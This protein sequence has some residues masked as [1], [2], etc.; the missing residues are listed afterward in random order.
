MPIRWARRAVGRYLRRRLGVNAA[1]CITWQ[2]LAPGMSNSWSGRTVAVTGAAGLLGSEIVAALVRSGALVHAMDV[3]PSALDAL[4]AQHGDRVVTHA[5]DLTD[6]R[7]I[8]RVAVDLARHSSSLDALVHCVGGN[9]RP[10]NP[11]SVPAESWHNVL[12]TNLVAPALVTNELIPLLGAV[13]SAGVVML[14][15]VNGCVSSPWPHYAAAKAGLAKLTRDLAVH[16][17]P[18]GIRVNAVAPG[19]TETTS[20]DGTTPRAPAVPLTRAAIPTEAVVNAVLFLA[21]PALSPCTT[22]QE[23]I[24]DAGVEVGLAGAVNRHR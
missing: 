16:L 24:V 5:A 22:G 8:Q 17:G 15:S 11:T 21:D 20:P 14:T 7:E 12:A 23:L 1:P 13:P 3:R 19:W 6:A 10:P 2:V 18:Q 4:V 9:D